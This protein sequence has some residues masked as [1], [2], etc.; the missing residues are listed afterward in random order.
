V[1]REWCK[2]RKSSF[3]TVSKEK[4]SI[5][6][7]NVGIGNDYFSLCACKLVV[8]LCSYVYLYTDSKKFWT[9]VTTAVC[10]AAAVSEAAGG[11][12][13]DQKESL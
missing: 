11:G 2:K 3:I 4:K 10:F 13:E 6:A 8:T 12:P 1:S 7:L 9:C 5:F